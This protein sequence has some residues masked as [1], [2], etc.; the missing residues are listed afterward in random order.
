LIRKILVALD[1]SDNAERALDFALDLAHKY[2]AEIQL[3]TVVPPIFLPV[4]SSNIVKSAAV[5]DAKK[6]LE[7]SF[8]GILLRAEEKVKK[9]NPKLR[10]SSKFEHGNPDEKIV[11]TAKHDNSDIVVIGSRGLGRRDYALGSVSS[12]VADNAPCP[13]L[14][15]R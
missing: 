13:V 7:D 1:G 10:I 6:Q 4:Y 15:C 5:E 14:I 3:V 8:K 2:S 9:E 12:K 11:E